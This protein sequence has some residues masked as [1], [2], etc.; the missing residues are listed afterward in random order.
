MKPSKNPEKLYKE[1][2]KMEQSGM[3]SLDI[4]IDLKNDSKSIVFKIGAF[5]AGIVAVFF[6]GWMITFPKM[7]KKRMLVAKVQ[8]SEIS[9]PS[10][11]I[12]KNGELMPVERFNATVNSMNTSNSTIQR[13]NKKVQK[14]NQSNS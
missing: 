13:F 10:T 2:I 12:N 4:P 11:L 1:A 3:S 14:F 7:N 5:A 9:A 6:I 8:I